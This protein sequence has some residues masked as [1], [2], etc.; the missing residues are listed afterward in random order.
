MP[1]LNVIDRQNIHVG[2]TEAKIGLQTTRGRITR[3]SP[4]CVWTTDNGIERCYRPQNGQFPSI[5]ISRVRAA[6][7][8]ARQ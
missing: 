3:V 1:R 6:D 8:I 2:Y 5:Y 4:S 7:F